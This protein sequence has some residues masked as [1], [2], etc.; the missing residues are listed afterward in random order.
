LDLIVN[1]I[2]SKEAP[3]AEKEEII[4]R[5]QRVILEN[6]NED[7]WNFRGY[8]AVYAPESDEAAKAHA[9]EYVKRFAEWYGKR[10]PESGCNQV[11]RLNNF[12]Q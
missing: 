5:W 6:K 8:P 2:P 7:V 3:L 12:S 10:C 1:N 9:V 11:P 4:H